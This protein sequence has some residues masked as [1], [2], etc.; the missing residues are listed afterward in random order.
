VK[1]QGEAEAEA[2]KQK[3][4]DLF[5]TSQYLKMRL[6]RSTST[7]TIKHQHDQY[8]HNRALPTCGKRAGA[9]HRQ[10]LETPNND[11]VPNKAL[12]S[13]FDSLNR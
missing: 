8:Q 6:P 7:S 10:Y 2:G 13:C 9:A 12:T 4:Q 5:L 3:Q 11:V 1:R